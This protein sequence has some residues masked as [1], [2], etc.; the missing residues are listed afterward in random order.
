MDQSIKD[1]RSQLLKELPEATVRVEEPAISEGTFWIDVKLAKQQRTIGF[2]RP[3]GFGIY[4]ENAGFGEG[5]ATMAANAQD[6]VAMLKTSLADSSSPA[7]LNLVV[8]RAR[9]IDRLA[10]FY[11]VLGLSFKKHRHGDGPEHL[12]SSVGGA[13]FEIYPMRSP[14]EGTT[15]T[16]LGFTV[17]SLESTINRLRQAQAT[18]LSEPRD[19]EFG[20]RAVVKD[21][22]GHKVEL[23]ESS[24][25]P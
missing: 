25:R 18:I 3:N 1:F 12:S 19:S 7:S 2:R 9:D 17:E 10:G 16:R 6:A 8:I 22:E 13:V 4:S 11:S 21:F 15:S 5:P 23:Y 14:D 20:R 24:R